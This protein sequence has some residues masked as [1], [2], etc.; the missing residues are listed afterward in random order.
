MHRDALF[1]FFAAVFL[2]V[3]AAPAF[4]DY[5]VALVIGNGAYT[6]VPHLPNPVHDAEDVAAALKRSGFEIIFA[7]DLDKAGMDEAMIKFARACAAVRRDQLSCAGGRP[8]ER[9]GRPTA[10]GAS[11]RCRR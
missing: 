1:A 6:R 2:S 5:R 9:R 4:A 11:R 7:T 3:F 8:V 10:H